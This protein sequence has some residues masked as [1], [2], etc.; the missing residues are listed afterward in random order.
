MKTDRKSARDLLVEKLEKV[1]AEMRMIAKES[2]KNY[3]AL[4]GPINTTVGE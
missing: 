4:Y 1:N 2:R 3:E